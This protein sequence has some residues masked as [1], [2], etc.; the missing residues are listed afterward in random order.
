MIGWLLVI[1]LLAYAVQRL[2]LGYPRPARA[3][4]WLAPREVHFLEAAA[5][6]LFPSGGA[7]PISG[8]EADLPRWVDDYLVVLPRSKRTQIR[9]LL[10]L[11]EQATLFFPAPG[12]L[13]KRGWRRF[14]ALDTEQ[15]SDVLRAWSR[16]SLYLRR[17]V[18]MALRAVLTMGYLGH[19]ATLRH[20]RLAP[21]RI[22]SPITEADVLYPRIGQHPD[23]NPL[24]PSD[25]T[26]PSDGVP[27]DLDGPLH[28]DYEEHPL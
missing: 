23:D 11:F 5:D 3:C 17:L 27:I 8:R 21:Y 25:I 7:M 9:L 18:F 13:W 2:W 1:V 4:E 20:L 26:A 15:R 28:P 12:P 24:T 22:E 16:S 10:L 6:A 19:P 14:S